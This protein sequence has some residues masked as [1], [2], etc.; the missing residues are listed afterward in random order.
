MSSNLFQLIAIILVSVVSSYYLS[1]LELSF[2]ESEF[3][4]VRYCNSQLAS[5]HNEKENQQAISTILTTSPIRKQETGLRP[6]G[7]EVQDV[8]ID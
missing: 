7:V 1:Q 2:D 6:V 5:I 4:C 3:Y 8:W